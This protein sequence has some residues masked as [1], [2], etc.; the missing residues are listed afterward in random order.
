MNAYVISNDTLFKI[1]LLQI[2]T[3]HARDELQKMPLYSLGENGI[4]FCRAKMIHLANLQ[5]EAAGPRPRD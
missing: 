2:S 5:G 4:A 1:T 3:R